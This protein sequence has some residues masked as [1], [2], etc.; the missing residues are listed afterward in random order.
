MIE[1]VLVETEAEQRL[2]G[3]LAEAQ[4]KIDQLETQVIALENDADVIYCWYCGA[5]EVGVRFH[6]EHQTPRARG[7]SDK[8]SNI[9]GACSDCNLA[10]GSMTVEEF[11]PR[12]EERHGTEVFWA[13]RAGRVPRPDRPYTWRRV[14][15]DDRLWEDLRFVAGAKGWTLSWA[16]QLALMDFVL[17]YR[18]PEERP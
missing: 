10:K 4:V 8:D 7:G 14:L 5:E 3:E 17:Q 1:D 11:R 12:F 2:R 16:V 6:R 18:A 15:L 9:V 13:E